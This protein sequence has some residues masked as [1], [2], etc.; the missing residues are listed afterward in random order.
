MLPGT[1]VATGAPT[2]RPAA[3]SFRPELQGLRALAVTLVVIYHVWLDRIS[4]GV[5][6]FFLISGFLITGQ[7]ARAAGRGG[8]TLR[9]MWGRMLKRLLPAALTVLAATIAAALVLLP[10]HRWFQ[11]IG[12]VV[13]SVF[14]VE[15]W[16]LAA[17]SVDY[18]AQHD[19]ASVVQ[20]FWSLSIQGQF[21]LVWPL[22]VLLVAWI[23]RRAGRSLRR[24][25]AFALGILFTASLA[26]SVVLTAADQPLAYFH[27]LTRVWEFAL[28][29]LLALA[30]DALVLP[31]AAR[32]TLGWL[33]VAGL[34]SCGMVLQVGTVFPGYAALWPTLCAAF[35]IVAGATGS[36]FAA[37]RP[38]SS[39][40][41]AYLGNLS[42]ALYL[43][44]WPVLLFYLLAR[45]R[46]QVG[47][48]GGA[49]V[50]GVSLALSALTYHFVEKPVRDSRIGVERPWGSYRFAVLAM[51][52]VLVAAGTWQF[53]ATERAGAFAAAPYDRNYPGANARLPGFQYQGD[54]DVEFGPPLVTLPDDFARIDDCGP[55]ERDERMEICTIP[56]E[57]PERRVVIVGD[58]HIQQYTASL[59]AIAEK[60][61]WEITTILRGACP[62]SVTSDVNPDDQSCVDWNASTLAEIID[63]APDAVLTLASRDVRAGLTENTPRGF[64]DQWHNLDAAGIPVLAVRDNP[65]FDFSP[66]DCVAANGPAAAECRAPRDELLAESPP[67][68]AVGDVPP[69]VSFL[70]FSDFFCGREWCTPVAGNV[71][72]FMDD[73]HLSATFMTTLAPVV[74]R[75]ITDALGW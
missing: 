46:E 70:D 65:R 15:N 35:V 34:V 47:L 11:T 53:V 4:G 10:E 24:T 75:D 9:P 50:I 8:I 58:S 61:G 7:L 18:F 37:D 25:L 51:I 30:V 1:S 14:Y 52:P 57:R 56:A 63:R 29:G 66:P 59:R 62:F 16:R 68:E 12:E 2:S 13:A 32:I 36:R 44:H 60:R 42:Y 40:P 73:N 27:S 23:A 71:Y 5:D 22:L 17:D 21:Y 41:M 31:R 43:W 33:G 67:Y 6:V 69:N 20:H 26:Y 28:G 74:E 72:T 55:A 39:R 54:E 49:V 64:V 19:S 38:L 48:L 45:G 3:R